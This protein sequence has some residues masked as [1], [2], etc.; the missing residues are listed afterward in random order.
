VKAMSYSNIGISY[1][2]IFQ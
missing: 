1:S 2:W